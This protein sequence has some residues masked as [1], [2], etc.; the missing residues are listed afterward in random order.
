MARSLTSGR[1]ARN[2]HVVMLGEGERVAPDELSDNLS[3]IDRASL[4]LLPADGDGGS[5]VRS[6]FARIVP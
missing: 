3:L 2:F 6:L 1:R 4:F 5:L